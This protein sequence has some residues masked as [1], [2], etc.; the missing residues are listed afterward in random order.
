MI[1]RA[2][3]LGGMLAG[4]FLLAGPAH[5]SVVVLDFEGLQDLEA[6]QDFYNGGTGS[7]GSSGVDYGVSFSG[8][9]LGIISG[10]AG[11]SGNF[12]N[13]PSGVT[14]MFFLDENNAIMSYADGFDT[15]FSFFYS[16]NTGD[17]RVEVYDGAGGTGVLLAALNLAQ[18]AN[19]GCPPGASTFYCNWDPIGV[20]FSGIAQSIK[21]IGAANF[22]AFDDITFGSETPGEPNGVPE[23]GTLLLLGSLM[24]GLGFR[25]RKLAR[26]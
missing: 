12:E 18:Q 15:G 3:I 23:P 25:R 17:G 4:A 2:N 20:A 19:L 26:G 16:S 22:I 10:L 13:A 8:A 6:I 1:K 5:A 21:F 9:T 11:G 7:L 24:A 14:V